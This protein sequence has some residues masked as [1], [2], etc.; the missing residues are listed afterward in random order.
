[1][2]IIPSPMANTKAA[3][4]WSTGIFTS[5]LSKNNI[6]GPTLAEVDPLSSGGANCDESS[7]SAAFY[8]AIK[9]AN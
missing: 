6:G 5:S 3:A 1:M 4:V 8:D 7:S 9:N 2:L